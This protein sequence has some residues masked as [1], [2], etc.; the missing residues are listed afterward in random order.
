MVYDWGHFG[1]IHDLG[2]VF[3][4]GK[5]APQGMHVAPEGFIVCL[6]LVTRAARYIPVSPLISASFLKR[7]PVVTFQFL[8]REWFSA[9]FA[10][11]SLLNVQR[12]LAS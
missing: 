12:C 5:S 11:L 4:W 2:L 6:E 1:A 8:D 3:R 7:H 10:R 9:V